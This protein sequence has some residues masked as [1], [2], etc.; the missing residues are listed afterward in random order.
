M[1][2]KTNHRSSKLTEKM[3]KETKKKESLLL[4]SLF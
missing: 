3:V 1:K 4:Y 2:Y